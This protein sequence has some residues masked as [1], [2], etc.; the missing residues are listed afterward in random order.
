MAVARAGAIASL[1]PFTPVLAREFTPD[2]EAWAYVKVYRRKGAVGA[3]TLTSTI[4]SVESGEAVWT[5]AEDR[6]PAAFRPADE[7]EYRVA[8]PLGALPAGGY[9]LRVEATCA[10]DQS[11]VRRELDFRVVAPIVA[12]PPVPGPAPG[13]P[14][15]AGAP[16]S[17]PPVAPGDVEGLLDRASAYLGQYLEDLSSVVS[18]ES[19]EQAVGGSP[20]SGFRAYRAMRRLRSDFLLVRLPGQAGW[21]PFRDVFEVDGRPVRDRDDRL[22][23]LFL[24]MPPDALITARTILD[25]GARY[26]IGRT[27]RNI[28][29]PVLP[30][31]FLLAENLT[32]FTFTPGGEDV[33]EGVRALRLDYEETSRPTLIRQAG[34]DRDMPSIGAFWIDPVTGRILKTQFETTD[35][36]FRM[37]SAVVYR[38]DEA[39]G[40]WVPGEMRETYTSAAERIYGKATYANF[41]RFQVKT[42]TAIRIPKRP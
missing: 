1:V 28:N 33:V 21:T 23:K 3:V 36:I 8:L 20:V 35:G 2:E 38:P 19:Y 17:R 9:R 16:P 42:D 34:T 4:T 40:L 12:A 14:R 27:Y 31:V 6:A 30:L 29:Q 15:P 5:S 37:L 26:N 39:L 22:R 41:R 18:E 11:A 25:E 10:E 7:T 32:R 13:P 24:E